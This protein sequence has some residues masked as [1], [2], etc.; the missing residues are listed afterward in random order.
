LSMFGSPVLADEQSATALVFASAVGRALSDVVEEF[1]GADLEERR[2]S[3]NGF[4]CD[5]GGLPVVTSGAQDIEMRCV[6]A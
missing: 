3:R 5:L 6:L 4:D 2:V 1:E